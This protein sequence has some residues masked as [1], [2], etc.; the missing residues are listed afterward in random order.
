[1]DNKLDTNKKCCH[2]YYID[3]DTNNIYC[4]M[5]LDYYNCQYNNNNTCLMKKQD[6]KPITFIKDTQY[7]Y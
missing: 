3:D 4:D 6:L 1:M 2:Q 7:V 5:Q